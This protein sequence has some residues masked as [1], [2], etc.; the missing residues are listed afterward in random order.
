MILSKDTVDAIE[1]NNSL[2]LKLAMALRFSERWIV[3]RA[4]QNK[5]NG[6]LTTFKAVQEIQEETKLKVEEILVDETIS[7]MAR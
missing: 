2:R 5:P 6:P 1:N 7:Q 4:R 3:L